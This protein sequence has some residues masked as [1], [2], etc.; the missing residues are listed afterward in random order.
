VASIRARR[1][2]RTATV[3][4]IVAAAVAG[5]ATLQIYLHRLTDAE[6][7]FLA[8]APAAAVAAGCG[9][10]TTVEPFPGGRDR[11]H[12]VS[13]ERPAPPALNEYPSVPPTSGPHATRTLPAG[14]YGQPPDI[15][16]AIHS[17][18]HAA[19]VVWFDP[20][21]ASSKELRELRGF[22]RRPDQS[23]H[24]IV[25]PYDYPQEGVAGRLP[26]GAA[27]VLTAWHRIRLCDL[28]SLPV[29]YDFVHRFRFN[30]YRWG[31]YE[32]EAPERFAPI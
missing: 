4:G 6:R 27:M 23:N 17:M 25:A 10:I 22:F 11:A 31:A 24:V 14:D 3:T 13:G 5:T 26:D 28:P 19:V 12:V 16:Q 1:R 2:W 9:P 18:E 8:E 15:G 7:A 32:G 21:S 20:S 30:L 29:A